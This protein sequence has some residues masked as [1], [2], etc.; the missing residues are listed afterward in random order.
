MLCA[1]K[2]FQI[3]YAITYMWNLKY[4]TDEPIDKTETDSQRWRTDLRLPR[5]KGREWDGLGIWG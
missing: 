4:G 3:S 5:R 2:D 1:L